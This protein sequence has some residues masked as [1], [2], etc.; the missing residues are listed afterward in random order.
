M[1]RSGSSVAVGDSPLTTKDTTAST[2]NAAPVN[3]AQLPLLITRSPVV[4]VPGRG[5]VSTAPRTREPPDAHPWLPLRRP[6]PFL[7]PPAALHRPDRPRRP[8][9]TNGHQTRTGARIAT[10][11][12]KSPA[13]LRPRG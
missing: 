11:R 10:K 7:G 4:D 2:T 9:A 6:G 5:R 3:G 13:I 12:R 1:S 8:R